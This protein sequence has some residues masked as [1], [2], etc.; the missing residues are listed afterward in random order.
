M[1]SFHGSIL[2][3]TSKCLFICSALLLSCIPV[4]TIFA[5]PS[6]SH[7]FLQRAVQRVSHLQLKPQFPTQSNMFCQICDHPPWREIALFLRG[8]INYERLWC[9]LNELITLLS[10]PSVLVPVASWFPSPSSSTLCKCFSPS[11]FLDLCFLQDRRFPF[12]SLL[13]LP[14]PIP[15]ILIA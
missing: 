10:F 11:Q 4:S 15:N 14:Q 7:C 3:R 1:K 2:D 6:N 9:S 13:T 12:R 8:R 5:T